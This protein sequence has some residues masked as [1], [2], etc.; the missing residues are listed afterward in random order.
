MKLSLFSLLF[1]KIAD[2]LY[3]IQIILKQK[4]K[5]MPSYTTSEALSVLDS[6]ITALKS[7]QATVKDALAQ[8]EPL[9]SANAEL[10]SVVTELQEADKAVDTK[11]AE[12]AEALNPTPVDPVDG[13]DFSDESMES[14]EGGT[15]IS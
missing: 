10:V 5:N 11:L 9:Q 8:L 12:L 14:E 15:P 4:T 3:Q 2:K 13:S 7:M 6:A 1:P